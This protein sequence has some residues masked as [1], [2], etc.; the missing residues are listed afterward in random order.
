MISKK[1]KQKTGK[2]L[3]INS[4]LTY[5]RTMKSQEKSS[6]VGVSDNLSFLTLPLEGMH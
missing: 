6:Q 4:F 3:G 1:M 5:T 2:L